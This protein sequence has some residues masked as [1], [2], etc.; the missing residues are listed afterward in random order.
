MIMNCLDFNILIDIRSIWVHLIACII[1]E[2]NWWFFLLSVE[3]IVKLSLSLFMLILF[4]GFLERA[5]ATLFYF[6]FLNIP[7]KLKSSNLRG[8]RAILAE[9][10][11][12][13][14]KYCKRFLSQ[15]VSFL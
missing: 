1:C 4:I 10:I 3:S 15:K 5:L 6:P 9:C 14:Y 11:F 13:F 12:K 8:K 7:L 2:Q